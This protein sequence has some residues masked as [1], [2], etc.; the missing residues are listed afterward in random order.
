MGGR[1]WTYEEVREHFSKHGCELLSKEYT[2]CNAPLRYRC[3]CGAENT[4]RFRVFKH[5][6]LKGARRGCKHCSVQRMMETSLARNGGKHLFQTEA[7]KEKRKK[8]CLVK[9]GVENPLQSEE[10]RQK[11]E[12]TCLRRYGVASVSQV[13][14]IA[15][16]QREG[17]R[18]KYGVDHFMRNPASAAKFH[19]TLMDRHGVPSLA[20]LSR[21]ASKESQTLFWKL[22]EKLPKDLQTKCYFAALNREF[23]VRFEGAFYKFDF[24]QS[25]LKRAIE[26]NG[27]NFHPKPDQPDDEV[28]WCAFHPQKTAKEARKYEAHKYQA[29]TSR[30][31][32]ILTVWDRQFHTNLS[33]LVKE[34][35]A[36]LLEDLG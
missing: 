19:Q 21:C 7:F 30:G 29:I 13:P 18:R 34:C 5:T 8:A 23:N 24:V 16:R 36:F 25:E 9:Y 14:E 12:Q 17:F 32:R 33:G 35:L 31:F 1:S 15:A 28:E 4:T 2:G 11:R 26:Y 20:H 10:V 3:G 27:W 22:H 6:T